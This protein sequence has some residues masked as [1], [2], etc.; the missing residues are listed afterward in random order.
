MSFLRN[1][2]IRGDIKS[3]KLWW[4]SV[5]DRHP[6]L[7]VEVLAATESPRCDVPAENVR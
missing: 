2:R 7:A 1:D 5:K 6:D 4:T 3:S